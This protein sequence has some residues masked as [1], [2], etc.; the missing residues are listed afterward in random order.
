MT[1]FQYRTIDL[2]DDAAGEDEQ[3]TLLSSLGIQIPGPAMPQPEVVSRF[4][5]FDVEDDSDRRVMVEQ[6]RNAEGVL[7]GQRVHE[8]RALPQVSDTRCHNTLLGSLGIAA[9]APVETHQGGIMVS[10]YGHDFQVVTDSDN[11]V[12]DLATA[13]ATWPA[14]FASIHT[15]ACMRPVTALSDE[16]TSDAMA[17]LEKISSEYLTG[18]I[19]EA[20]ARERMHELFA[21]SLLPTNAAGDKPRSRFVVTDDDRVLNPVGPKFGGMRDDTDTDDYGAPRPIQTEEMLAPM[22]EL[23]EQLG[24]KQGFVM[25]DGCSVGI[26]LEGGTFD[27]PTGKG[28]FMPVFMRG[29]NGML[30]PTWAFGRTR[31]VKCQNECPSLLTGTNQATWQIRQTRSFFEKLDALTVI[32][33]RMARARELCTRQAEKLASK[34][35]TREDAQRILLKAGRLKVDEDG[36]LTDKSEEVLEEIYTRSLGGTDCTGNRPRAVHTVTRDGVTYPSG[37]GFRMGHTDYDTHMA[38]VNAGEGALL[39]GTYARE[40]ASVQRQLLQL[41]STN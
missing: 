22:A 28:L 36:Q 30:T 21:G 5:D 12:R 34:V 17:S 20:S 3:P 19:S 11:L 32:G 14:V 1:D 24:I 15:E 2:G 27:T 9:P 38:R 7:V 16:Q 25:H 6:T 33:E 31:I 8:Y 37:W 18:K 4:R 23:I 10:H 35:V 40:H 13:K 26:Q 39:V 29:L 41:G